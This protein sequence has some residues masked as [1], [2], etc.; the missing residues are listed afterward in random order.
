MKKVV[1]SLLLILIN[2]VYIQGE[3]KIAVLNLEAGT[4]L[5]TS[6]VSGLQDMLISALQSS[7]EFT[8]MERGRVRDLI[9]EMGISNGKRPTQAQLRS[10]AQKLGV[11]AV[12][13]GTVNFQARDRY[14]EDVITGTQRGEYNVDIRLVSTASG[15]ILSSVGDTQ[16]SNETTRS[17]I[18][19]ISSKLI[20][21]YDSSTE[22]STISKPV[23]LNGYLIVYP[24]DLG[25]FPTFPSQTINM[26]NRQAKYG[27][28]DW[29]L[30]TSEEM[31]Q[32]RANASTIGLQKSKVYATNHTVFN[33]GNYKVRLVRSKVIAQHVG[34]STGNI[35]LIPEVIDLGTIP[36]LRGSAEGSFKIVNESYDSV[37]I[38]SI[39]SPSS[40]IQILP[41]DSNLERGDTGI[42]RFT[43][44]IN[45]RQGLNL[46]R[47]I[48]IELSN[49]KRF[50]IT[51]KAYVK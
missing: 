39:S 11:E 41:Y 40:N 19:R 14:I 15:K 33:G 45:G 47:N 24:Q 37:T 7:G 3:I 31:S 51:V 8:I 23:E 6:Q 25:S 1:I 30:P 10:F 9:R 18:N 4:G 17:L 48:N 38:K 32:M 29:R 28:T 34:N 26:I 12:V 36:V 16:R 27:Y 46:K 13:V 43:L 35:Y 5:T 49:G 42:I 44:S 2:V 22:I 21:G 20:D 50:D